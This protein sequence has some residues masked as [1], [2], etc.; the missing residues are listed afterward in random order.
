MIN[1]CQKCGYYWENRKPKRPRQCPHCW[2]SNWDGGKPNRAKYDFDKLAVGES[3][4]LAWN[5]DR[6]G[7]A[8]IR[9]NVRMNRAL[10][11]FSYRTGREFRKYPTTKGLIITRIS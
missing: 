2:T 3:M 9:M 8:D 10:H 11:S 6:N 7:R 4:T 5:E 1:E